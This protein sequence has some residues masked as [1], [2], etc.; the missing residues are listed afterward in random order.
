ST[1]AT[2]LSIIDAATRTVTARIDLGL[3]S[4]GMAMASDARPLWVASEVGGKVLAVDLARGA[5]VARIPVGRMPHTMIRSRDG[6]W[7]YTANME[8]DTLSVISTA[9]R[10]RARPGAGPSRRRRRRARGAGGRGAPPRGPVRV[11]AAAAQRA[12]RRPRHLPDPLARRDARLRRRGHGH[13]DHRAP[14]PRGARHGA[15]RARGQ[16]ALPL[17]GH[18][19]AA[20]PVHGRRARGRAEPLDALGRRAH[21]AGRLPRLGGG[22]ERRPA[23][24]PHPPAARPPAPPA[25]PAPR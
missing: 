1:G 24:P 20:A 9:R 14:R 15:G 18:L 8:D 16:A 21:A 3:N 6:A 13:R 25:P 22:R 17:L 4:H 2:A 7:L 12:G 19:R 10:A 5:V 11:L 23:A